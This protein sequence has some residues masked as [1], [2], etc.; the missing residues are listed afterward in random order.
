MNSKTNIAKT[1]IR[2]LGY[3]IIIGILLTNAELRA[4]KF[5]AGGAFVMGFPQGEFRD[6]VDNTGLGGTAHF[7]YRIGQ[8]P[9]MIG[10]DAGFM[11]YGTERRNEPF[12]LTIPDV[13]VE[14]KTTNNIVLWHALA[15]I[16]PG[17]GKVQPYFD[18]MIGLKY[19]FTTTSIHSE[20]GYDDPIA[21]S[22]NFDDLAFSYGAGGGLQFQVYDTATGGTQRPVA[23]YIDL[24]LKYLL[25]SEAEYLKKGSITRTPG[26]PLTYDVLKSNTDI[27]LFNIGV[28]VTF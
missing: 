20:E 24:N 21:S 11:I 14:V 13:T 8:S 18:G 9:L 17:T 2:C 25:G 19:L 10:M 23:V 15:R 4:Q 7:L 12:S 3:V 26:Q 6:N 27:L 22:K 16:Q 28:S 5:Q 1:V